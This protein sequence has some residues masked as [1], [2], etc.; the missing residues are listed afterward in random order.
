MRAVVSDGAVWIER[1]QPTGAGP[2]V[3]VKDLCDVAGSVTT[4]GCLAVARRAAPAESDAACVASVR[5]AGGVLV[6]KTNLHELAYGTSGANPWYGMPENPSDPGRVPGGSSSGSA[7]A[8]ALRQ[9]DVAIGSDTGGSVRI[10]AACCGVVGLKTTFGRIPLEGVFPL[11]P[12]YDTIGPLGRSV[13]EAALGLALLEGEANFEMG[14]APSLLGRVRLGP[15]VEV[16]PE[17]EQAVD[18]ALAASGLLVEETV[19]EGWLGAWKAH[20]CLLEVEA[21]ASDGHLVLSDPAGIGDE[22]RERLV[23][24]GRRTPDEAAAAS[25]LGRAWSVYA[26]E[27]ASRFGVLALATLPYRP[28]AVG[29][30]RRGFNIL[31]APVNLCGLPALSVPIPVPSGSWWTGLQLV[32]PPGS[33]DVLF[34]AGQMVEDAVGSR[35]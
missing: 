24:A 10:P 29:S 15:A 6:G 28:P 9:C 22:V 17:V 1:W 21:W 25:A 11:A 12:S 33:E 27:A 34:A 31:T 13:R 3:G 20:Q 8:L 30:F 23:A 4:A 32:G 16:D 5:A 2:R 14:D 35:F 26:S 7:V 19:V 18:A